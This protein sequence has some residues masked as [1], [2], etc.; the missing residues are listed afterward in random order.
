VVATSSV[1]GPSFQGAC[2]ALKDDAAKGWGQ[3]GPRP[4][5]P[6]ASGH[7]GFFLASESSGPPRAEVRTLWGSCAA[8]HGWAQ[9]T[10]LASCLPASRETNVLEFLR[11]PC[12]PTSFKSRKSDCDPNLLHLSLLAKGIIVGTSDLPDPQGAPPPCLETTTTTIRSHC[13]QALLEPSVC[14][15]CNDIPANTAPHCSSPQGRIFQVEYA[16][17]AVKQ[18]S[19][20]VGI[21]SKTHVVLV[22]VKVPTPAASV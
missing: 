10:K 21:V 15:P 3:S 9:L 19:V 11:P 20:V 1:S 7:R 22:A 5:R 16:A 18:G 4:C 13:K 14:A 6:R 17:E 2:L 8:Q 12:Q